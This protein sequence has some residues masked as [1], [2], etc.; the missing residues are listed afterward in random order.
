MLE[1]LAKGTNY[2]VGNLLRRNKVFISSSL[3]FLN[4]ERTIDRNYFDYVRLSTLELISYEI[5]KKKISGNVAELGVYKGRFARYINQYFP[6]RILYLFDTFKGFDNRDVISETNKEFSSGEQDFSDTSVEGVLKLM[7]F[8]QKCNPVIGF[9]PDSAKRIDDSF[10]FVSLDADLYE[11]IY[12][13]LLFFYPKLVSGG[14]IFIH[15]FNNDA[16]KGA[17][18]AV[19]Q[20]CQEFNINFL[21][22]PDVGGSAI[23]LK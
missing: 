13:G 14:Y 16:Y 1:V 22:I 6:D 15:D 19:E 21:P 5:N 12:N 8:P 2:L 20:F 17:R 11:P 10:V 3:A 23:I 4:R 18:K 7:P 9:F